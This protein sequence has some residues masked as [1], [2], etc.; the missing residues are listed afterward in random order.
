MNRLAGQGTTVLLTTQYMEEAEAL[1]DAL[2]VIDSGRVIASGSTAELRARLGGQML[3]IQPE[4]PGD[5]ARICQVLV[6]AGH[7][8]AAVMA[9]EGGSSCR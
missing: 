3:R 7:T 9:D 1:A 8:E 2:V 4:E 6:A 5:L